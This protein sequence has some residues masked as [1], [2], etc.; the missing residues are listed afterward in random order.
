MIR[1]MNRDGEDPMRTLALHRS[2]TPAGVEHL[3]ALLTAWSSFTLHRSLTPPVVEQ[4][5]DIAADNPLYHLAFSIPS[6]SS[7]KGIP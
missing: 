7:L 2:L 1:K 5:G 4:Y 3:R 6:E